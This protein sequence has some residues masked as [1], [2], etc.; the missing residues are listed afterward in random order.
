MRTTKL[1]RAG[2]LAIVRI[3]HL[4]KKG[5]GSWRRSLWSKWRSRAALRPGYWLLVPPAR[6]FSCRRGCGFS[7]MPI[8]SIKGIKEIATT[9]RLLIIPAMVIGFWMSV[10]GQ[11][12]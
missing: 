6:L 10:A 7:A 9:Q 12:V 5:G 3:W 4:E 1:R 11:I 2:G 8:Q